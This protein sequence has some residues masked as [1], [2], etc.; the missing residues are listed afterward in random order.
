[1]AVGTDCDQ[2]C[3]LPTI[4]QRRGVSQQLLHAL[5]TQRATGIHFQLNPQM[6]DDSK[7]ATLGCLDSSADRTSVDMSRCTDRGE[8][9]HVGEV[10]GHNTRPNISDNSDK[11]PRHGLKQAEV[12]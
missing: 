12:S 9:Y 2:V 4:L 10:A 1:M 11:H 5:R 8:A 3:S 6:V 7:P